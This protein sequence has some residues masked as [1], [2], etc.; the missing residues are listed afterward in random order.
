MKSMFIKGA[1][2]GCALATLFTA[3]SVDA[4]PS[5]AS[6]G[7]KYVFFFLGDGMASVQMQAAEAY[8][9]SLMEG[10]EDDPT[11]LKAGTL[12][13]NLLPIS[14]MATTYSDTRLITD[15]A[16]GTAFAC[17]VKTAAGII[18]LN[19]DRNI[20]YKSVAELAHEQGK[21]VG[22]ISSVSLPHATPA[23]YYAKVNSRNNYTEIGYQAA[24]SGFEFFGGGQ[25]RYMSSTDN[26]GGIAVSEAFANNDYTFVSSIEDLEHVSGK[27]VCSVATS[28]DSNAMPYHMDSPPENFTL[29]EVTAA[30]INRLQND[31]DGFF[32]SVEGGKIDWAGHA[33]DAK[34]NITDTIA[35][36]DAVGEALAFYNEHP[37]ETLIVVTGDHETGGMSIGYTGTKYETAFETLEAQTISYDLFNRQIMGDYKSSHT[38]VDA[39]TSNIDADMMD[40]ISNC[41]GLVWTDLSEYQQ[42]QLEA[43][44][45]RELGGVKA[46]SR[47]SGY[48]L[49]GYTDVDYTIYGGYKAIA[50]TCTHILNQ[51][52][53]LYWASTSHTAVPVPVPVMAVGFDAYRF[54]GFY[55]NTDIAKFLGQAMRTPALPVQDPDYT[56]GGLA[57]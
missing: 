6:N 46:D 50:V 9:A 42:E 53:G 20:A 16:A 45:D 30:A 55:D 27:V 15:S 56:G 35:F 39:E 13:M 2:A 12:N 52:S 36:D 19:T 4:R 43:A 38:W 1:A 41:F 51:E 11:N 14:G 21:S 31:P 37:A 44:Y 10:G 34:A 25:F 22:I 17:G 47:A 40:I 33:N 57:Y 18:G 23:S 29:A 5:R 8:K 26:A 32:I 3:A 7:A 49:N 24:L 48:D 54:N 28:Y